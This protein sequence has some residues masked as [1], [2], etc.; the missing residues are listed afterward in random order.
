MRGNLD[1]ELV[2]ID[3][4]ECE[5]MFNLISFCGVEFLDLPAE[6]SDSSKAPQEQYTNSISTEHLINDDS[7]SSLQEESQPQQPK[8]HISGHR[9]KKKFRPDS[10]RFIST[11]EQG[12]M[13]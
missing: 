7:V 11:S 12:R 8:R 6:E 2:Q 10:P 5:S 1:L 3:S 9:I 13:D 4:P